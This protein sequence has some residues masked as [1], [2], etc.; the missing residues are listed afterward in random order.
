MSRL[1]QTYRSLHDQGFIPIFVDDD[2][3]TNLLLEA[4][5][6]AGFS[7]IEYTLR[8]RDAHRMIPW[9]RKN[10]PELYL[11]VGSTIDD[12]RI[13]ERARR[14]GL[15]QLMT[16]DELADIGVDGLVS[17]HGFSEETIRKFCGSHLMIPAAFTPTEALRQF[18]SGAHFIKVLGPSLD[19]VRLIRGGPTFGYCP[20]MVTGGMTSERIPEAVRAGAILTG[21]GF[22]VILQNNNPKIAGKKD[23]AKCLRHFQEIMQET[24][25]EV[26]PQL[27]RA[28]KV[29]ASAWLRALPHQHHFGD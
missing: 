6:E 27:A 16:L 19:A 25:N 15:Q 10:Y 4:C 5:L 11:L 7:V 12:D 17:M 20:V 21:T 9:I 18:A 28:R 23:M 22:D 29:D 1:F 14:Q 13:V 24:V 2:L 3:H 26:Y 8:R